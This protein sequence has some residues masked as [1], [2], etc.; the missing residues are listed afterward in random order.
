MK[1]TSGDQLGV[2]GNVVFGVCVWSGCFVYLGVTLVLASSRVADQ[3]MDANKLDRKRSLRR[4]FLGR[5]FRGRSYDHR[6]IITRRTPSLT[7]VAFPWYSELSNIPVP[8]ISE[9]GALSQG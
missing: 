4:G 9:N 8:S 1:K 5:E 2:L 3:R 6:V 7:Y